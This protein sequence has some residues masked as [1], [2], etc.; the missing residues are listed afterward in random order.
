MLFY[1]YAFFFLP[2]IIK[3]RSLSVTITDKFKKKKKSCLKETPGDK[4][5]DLYLW[6]LRVFFFWLTFLLVTYYLHIYWK[7]FSF[8]IEDKR[9]GRFKIEMNWIDDVRAL[10]VVSIRIKI[11]LMCCF[12][13][14]VNKTWW[15]WNGT[16]QY[17]KTCMYQ[18]EKKM[19]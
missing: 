19:R 6:K 8:L 5:S 14:D 18:K 15:F 11:V 1:W 16:P 12:L 13:V 3:H 7:I 9:K 10:L 2:N 4:I 17:N